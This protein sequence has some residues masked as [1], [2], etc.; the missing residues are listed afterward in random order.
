MIL[1]LNIDGSA[2][3]AMTRRFFG[4]F[5]FLLIAM[6][7]TS[8]FGKV[9]EFIENSGYFIYLFHAFPSFV[10]KKLT[11]MYIHP[12]TAFGSIT[13]YFV[14]IA[15]MIGFSL[16]IY[17]AFLKLFPRFTAVITGKKVV[18]VAI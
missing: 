16:F 17:S 3:L 8:K 2:F 6:F 9:N 12:S 1:S 7:V 13:V 14:R 5:A 10:F 18:K 11:G 15:V 4:A